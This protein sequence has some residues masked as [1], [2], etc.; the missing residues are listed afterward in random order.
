MALL[1]LARVAGPK[2]HSILILMIGT[3]EMDRSPQ[4]R[5]LSPG[6]FPRADSPSCPSVWGL[7]LLKQAPNPRDNSRLAYILVV[8]VDNEITQQHRAIP[9]VD[10]AFQASVNPT[11]ANA[12]TT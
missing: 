3:V 8:K 6:N 11:A 5:N 2:K 7:Q 4:G 12:A 9:A 1:T 10:H